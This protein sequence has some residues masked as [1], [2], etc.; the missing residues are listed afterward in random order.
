MRNHCRSIAIV[1]LLVCFTPFLSALP[2]QA[3]TP[4]CADSGCTQTRQ[5]LKKICDYIVSQKS[6]F[7]HI[8][9]GGYYM[10]TLVGG[11]EVLGD[12]RYL[13]TAIAYGD[14]LLEKQ[15][16]N[17][18]WGTGYGSVYL[19]DTGSALGLFIVLY[20]HVDHDRQKAYFDAVQSYINSIQKEGM[21]HADGA[22]G[23]GWRQTKGVTVSGP[24]LDEYTLSS[25]LTGGEIFTWMYHV[26]RKDEYREVA[27]K[28]LKWILSTMRSDGNIPYVLAMEGADLA[29]RGDPK[30]DSNLWSEMTCGTAGYAG[31]GIIAFDLYCNQ[32]AWRA[33]IEKAVRPNIEFL[34]RTQLPD[35]TWSRMGEKTWD[36]TRSPGIINY[37]TWYYEHVHKDPRIAKQVQQ[38]DAFILNPQN[39]KSYGQLYEGA[40]PGPVD[41]ASAFNT[42][43]SLTGRAVADILSPGVDA[44]W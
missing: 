29:K 5:L 14:Y 30:N 25:A 16:L 22:L 32:P 4:F 12:H 39:R 43:T 17:G 27:Y 44:R 20:K 15:M 10:R 37:L 21:I 9:V 8:Y 19:A 1:G 2:A 26:T 31:E 41:R 40:N 38:F 7:S 33:W 13:N 42:A 36:R 6:T 18:L 24:I 28:A 3:T 23:T 34:L 11:Y 35:G